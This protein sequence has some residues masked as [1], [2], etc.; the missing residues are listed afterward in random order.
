[1]PMIGVIGTVWADLY[2]ETVK[3]FTGFQL[4]K[5][6]DVGNMMQWS[7]LYMKSIVKILS[8]LYPLWIT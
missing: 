7:I 2:T 3:H 8:A 5:W 6:S 4:D 1:M